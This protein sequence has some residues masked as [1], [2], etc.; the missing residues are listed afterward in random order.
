MILVH[1]SVQSIKKWEDLKSF[2]VK[3]DYIIYLILICNQDTL[4]ISRLKINIWETLISKTTTISRKDITII[5]IRTT[6]DKLEVFRDRFQPLKWD[7]SGS[8]APE[9]V[10]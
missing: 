3:L 7:K 2:F 9:C 5:S 6:I 4:H 1:F 10:L 8:V